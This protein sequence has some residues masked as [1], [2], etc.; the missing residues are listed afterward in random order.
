MFC[1]LE[2]H[3]L[4]HNPYLQFLKNATVIMS[5]SGEHLRWYVMPSTLSQSLSEQGE[6]KKKSLPMETSLNNSIPNPFNDIIY[7]LPITGKQLAR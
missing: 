6:K 2:P 3:L 4:D 7:R 5:V 1:S